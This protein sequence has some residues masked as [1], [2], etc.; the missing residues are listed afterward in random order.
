MRK[1]K[2]LPSQNRESRAQGKLRR[3]VLEAHTRGARLWPTT[4]PPKE[5]KSIKWPWRAARRRPARPHPVAL[6]TPIQRIAFVASPPVARATPIQRIALV[7]SHLRRPMR[8]AHQQPR[9]PPP[10]L[11]RNAPPSAALGAEPRPAA[12][13]A[14]IAPA[15]RAA[16]ARASAPRCAGLSCIFSQCRVP[17]RQ[18]LLGQP[19]GRPCCAASPLWHRSCGN[20]FWHSSLAL[21]RGRWEV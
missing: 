16:R 7:A 15:C 2:S 5:S 17:L 6:A 1:Q 3:W 13:R 19:L 8:G 4:C 9:S 14:T 11:P 20:P 12:S 10:K 18:L 21:P